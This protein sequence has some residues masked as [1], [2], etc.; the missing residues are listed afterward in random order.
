[1]SALFLRD[2]IEPDSR[3]LAHSED[4]PMSLYRSATL[5]TAMVAAAALTPRLG[6]AQELQPVDRA[7][8]QLGFTLPDFDTSV[9]ADGQT[10]TGDQVDLSRDLG[11]ESSNVVGSLGLTWRPWENHEFSLTYF[12]D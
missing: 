12:N 6:M 7:S 5:V 8:I 11:L 1:M 10:S 2:S 9:R 3:V 4:S